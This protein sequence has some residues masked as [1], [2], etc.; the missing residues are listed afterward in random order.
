MGSTLVA[1]FVD[2]EAR[3]VHIGHVGDSRCYRLRGDAIELLTRDHSLVNDALDLKPDLTEDELA[4]LPKNIITRALGMKDGVKVDVRSEVLQPGDVYLLCSD[5][6]SGMVSDE[7]MVEAL[8]ITEDLKEA[9]ELLIAMANDAGGT[10]N[11]SA[12]AVR[13]ER[14]EVE[15]PADGPRR[16]EASAPDVAAEPAALVLDDPIEQLKGSVPPEVVSLLES[17]AEVDVNESTL[18]SV[19]THV[20]I[21]RCKKCSTELFVGNLFCVECGTPVD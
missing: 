8:S 18:M 4:R 5:G 20:R 17:G 11:I 15:A 12:V 6:L 2:R 16:R 3:V 7:Q 19:P 1:A 9:C 14:D 10:D 21:A 13:I